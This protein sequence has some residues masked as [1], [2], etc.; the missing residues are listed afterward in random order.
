MMLILMSND[1]IIKLMKC[2]LMLLKLKE[3]TTYNF[4]VDIIKN[5]MSLNF[6]YCVDH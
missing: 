2:D 6:Q 3:H 5:E 1:K 4:N